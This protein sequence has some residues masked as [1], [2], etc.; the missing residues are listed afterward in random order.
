MWFKGLDRAND[1]FVEI[2]RWDGYQP[3]WNWNDGDIDHI[4]EG[5][6]LSDEQASPFYGD[7]FQ[8]GGPE[9]LEVSLEPGM[10]VVQAGTDSDVST[11]IT[12]EASS[13]LTPLDDTEAFGHILAGGESEI[14]I[15][16]FYR[17]VDTYR[18]E[19]RE[20]EV[21][22]VQM[23]SV[24]GDPVM[25]VYKSGYTSYVLVAS[26]DDEG[27]GLYGDGAEIVFEAPTTG[28]YDLD[29]TAF[30]DFPSAYF[31]TVDHADRQSPSC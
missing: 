21:L 26:S 31:L 15:L 6:Q 14:G 20:G 22:R 17:D 5:T 25:S 18:L 7:E 11:T 23:V 29:V 19:L 4:Y 16:S 28:L 3:T 27:I 24:T 2:T 1:V 9:T 12:V 13:P 8:N 30:G 10:Y